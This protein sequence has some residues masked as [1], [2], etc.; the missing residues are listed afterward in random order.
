MKDLSKLPESLQE[1]GK[2]LNAVVSYGDIQAQAARL[3]DHLE[4][5]DSFFFGR[6]LAVKDNINVAGSITTASSLMLADYKAV[7]NADIIDRI[8]SRGGI[9]A[10]KTSLDELGMGGSNKSAC[11]GPVLNP[12]DLQRISGGSSGGSAALVATEVIDFALGT[13]TGDSIRKPAAYCGV[14]GLKPT[15]GRLS[16]YGVIPYAASL[17][18]VGFFSLDVRSSAKALSELAGWDAK[19]MTSLNEPAADYAAL[20]NSD[21]RNKKIAVLT[22]VVDNVRNPEVAALFNGLCAKLTEQGAIITPVTMA[23]NSFLPKKSRAPVL[24]LLPGRTKHSQTDSP[25]S[26]SSTTSA[27][28]PFSLLP[29]NLAGIT[30]ES[31]ITMQSPLFKRSGN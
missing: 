16:R 3:K 6:P 14:V 11:T 17:D 30:R 8:I 4:Y 27:A 29:S 9:I 20:L 31:F 19:D 13:D 25:I 5:N 24:I 1:A 15:Y 10:A 2:R 23:V 12:F 21:I 7:I 22:N 28:P 18:H 26:Q